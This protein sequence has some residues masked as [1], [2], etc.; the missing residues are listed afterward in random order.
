M[1]K[2]INCCVENE[3]KRFQKRALTMS[4]MSYRLLVELAHSTHADGKEIV[5]NGLDFAQKELKQVFEKVEQ[6]QE[7]I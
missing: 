1:V 7:K 4:T 3:Y 6:L 2:V 5:N